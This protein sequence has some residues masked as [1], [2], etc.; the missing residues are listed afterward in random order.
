M[1][2][3]TT[4]LMPAVEMYNLLGENFC[5]KLRLDAYSI[6]KNKERFKELVKVNVIE[7]PLG[8]QDASSVTVDL[9][10]SHD[11]DMA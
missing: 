4:E 5:R 1:P 6:S 8:A 9:P 7:F 3:R 10:I 11:R 2:L